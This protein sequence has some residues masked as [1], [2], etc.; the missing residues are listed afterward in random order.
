MTCFASRQRLGLKSN[1]SSR[2]YHRAHSETRC[3]PGGE[4]SHALVI[5]DCLGIAGG[6]TRPLADLLYLDMMARGD[7]RKS[8][9]EPLRFTSVRE[10]LQTD[11]SS[12]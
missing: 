1:G 10:S 8:N 2:R 9:L 5:P 7:L 4:Q 11:R 6:T 3:E 12:R